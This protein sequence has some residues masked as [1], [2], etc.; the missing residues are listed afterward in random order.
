MKYYHYT[1]L[2][3][4]LG[5]ILAGCQRDKLRDLDCDTN[6][7]ENSI[8]QDKGKGV[9][10]VIDCPIVI[11]DGTLTIE[12]DVHIQFEG[13][14]A[15]FIV[16]RNGALR[17]N[18][19]NKCP[20][21]LEGKEDVAGKWMGIV[22]K[23]QKEANELNHVVL[24][25]AGSVSYDGVHPQAAIVVIE[26]GKVG[27]QHSEIRNNQ[28]YGVYLE[29]TEDTQLD[30]FNNNTIGNNT[31][32]PL[33]IPFSEITALS[34][35][36]ILNPAGQTNGKNYVEVYGQKTS[37][38]PLNEISFG[39]SIAA[40]DVPYRM[41]YVN[42]I[43][44]CFVQVLNSATFE[45]AED[46]SLVVMGNDTSDGFTAVG[47]LNTQTPVTFTKAPEVNAWRGIHFQHDSPKNY[48]YYCKIE[49]GGSQKHS[50]SNGI[51]NIVVGT[52]LN[53]GGAHIES[54]VI[55]HS[56]GWGVH[57]RLS[58]FMT[59]TANFY[60]GNTLGDIGLY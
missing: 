26:E 32:A 45:F 44:K 51:G 22:Y 19:T 59:G 48:L 40:L 9:D 31:A 20:I 8:L 15:G 18:G 34:I 42:Q 56:K 17:F 54:C 11:A 46:A 3:F 1:L 39:G 57:H 14:N 13:A 4:L 38:S 35:N 36:N 29:A 23:S 27:I 55:N 5:S 25:N 16:E 41:F 60:N 52:N 7:T 43:N 47:N 33:C 53:W 50:L 10:Y 37:S 24:K 30:F 6:I 58:S 21:I 28:G 2:F 12:A 49:Y